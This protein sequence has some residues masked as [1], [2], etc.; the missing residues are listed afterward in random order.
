MDDL[1]LLGRII[2][3]GFFAYS[4]AN[5]LLTNAASAQYAASKGVPMPEVAVV[6]AGLLILA[7]GLSILIGFL[8]QAGV[9]CIALFLLVVTPTMHAFWSESGAERMADLINFTKNVALMG[10]ALTMLGVPRPWPYS[11]ERR[12]RIAA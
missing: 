12:T 5:L 2:F 6:V 11:L 1:F 3:G 4:G 10:G 8:P 7:G 9:G